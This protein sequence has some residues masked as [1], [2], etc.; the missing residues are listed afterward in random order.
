MKKIRNIIIVL[1]LLISSIFTVGFV[2][3]KPIPKGETGDSA[4]KLAD[5][6]LKAINQTGFDSL[7]F[8]AWDYPRGHTYK[9]NKKE[10]FVIVN[11]DN[12][13]VELFLETM[14]GIAFRNGQQILD[15]NSEKLI[16]KAWK[17]FANDSFWLIAPFKIRD[18]GTTRSLVKTEQG[19]ALLVTYTSGGVTPG[20]SYLW[21]LNE[22]GLPVAW[23]MWV[24][25]IPIGGITF[26]WQNWLNYQNVPFSTHHKGPFSIAIDLEIK[27]IR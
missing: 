14:E 23:Q 1:I 22:E 15:V 2:F 26:T 17:L 9:W 20:D 24:K 10:N 8:I 16:Q 11:W 21:I 4:E 3:D 19:D 18:F 25:I 12:I 13:Q 6:M 7:K 27:D 5:K